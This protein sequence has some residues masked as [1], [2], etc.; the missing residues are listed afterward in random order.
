MVK[1]IVNNCL[2]IIQ[3]RFQ[4][5]FAGIKIDTTWRPEEFATL[6]G[7]VHS[8]P[9]RIE[10]DRNRNITGLVKPGDK[11]VFSYGVIYD[12]TKQPEND[13]PVYRNLITHEG[14]EYWKV[15]IG[16]IF[17]K[18]S[19]SGKIEMIT[20]NVL[21]EPYADPATGKKTDNMGVVKAKPQNIKSI[22]MGDVVC[23]EDRFIQRYNIFGSEHLIIPSRR[24][25]AKF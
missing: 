5:Y 14:Q 3:K 9:F 16:E 18:I 19:G 12:F 15:D 21:L 22:H 24:I 7:V 23:F 17:C 13:T 8:A 25:L 1:A 2:V 10:Y 20:D 6:E 11:I 4:D